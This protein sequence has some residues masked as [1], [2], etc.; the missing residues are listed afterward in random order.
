MLSGTGSIAQLPVVVL[1][2]AFWSAQHVNIKIYCIYNNM[3]HFK[4]K[5]IIL[6]FDT[7]RLNLITGSLA[8]D[9]RA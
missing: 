6:S 9:L 2:A 4:K 3:F 8:F 1:L 5:D 7:I